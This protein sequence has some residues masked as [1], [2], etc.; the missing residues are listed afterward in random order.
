[1]IPYTSWTTNPKI[2]NQLQFNGWRILTGPHILRR[3]A[4]RAPIWPDGST[5][6]YCLDNGAWT[7][8]QSGEPFDAVSF[9]RTVDQLGKGSDFI[10]IPDIVAGG[11]AS[12]RFSEGWIDELNQVG[13]PLLLAVQDGMTPAMVQPYVEDGIGI[14][15]GGSTDWKLETI[16]AWAALARRYGR[17]CHVGRVNSV[18]RIQLCNNAG[19]NS[20]DGTRPIR[21]PD[22]IRRFTAESNQQTLRGQ[23]DCFDLFFRRA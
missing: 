14:F 6:K 23:D 12:L 16:P 18:R 13:S 21:W 22:C 10:V 20:F 11:L 2:L 8:H 1:M 4:W 19:V 15:V 3:H 7:A 5:V 17:W 9:R